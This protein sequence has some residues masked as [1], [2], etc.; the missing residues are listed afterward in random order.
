ME[1]TDERR[2]YHGFMGEPDRDTAGV[3]QSTNGPVMIHV[4]VENACRLRGVGVKAYGPMSHTAILSLAAAAAHI[5][6]MAPLCGSC[7]TRMFRADSRY[8]F[9]GIIPMNPETS[10]RRDSIA[11][12]RQGDSIEWADLYLARRCADWKPY[13]LPTGL[14][15]GFTEY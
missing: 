9:I 15:N 7:S 10:F 5:C 4:P 8:S 13:S 12:C 3:P 11:L 1:L 2:Q 6:L 14:A